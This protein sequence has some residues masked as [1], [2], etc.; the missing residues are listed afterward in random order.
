MKGT[1]STD[2]N[3]PEITK[4]VR[5]PEVSTAS[6]VTDGNLFIFLTNAIYWH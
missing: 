5:P 1:A 4:V 3:I 6:Y 2:S